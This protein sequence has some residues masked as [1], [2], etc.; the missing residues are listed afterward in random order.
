MTTWDAW[1]ALELAD[2]LTDIRLDGTD[3]WNAM[4]AAQDMLRAAVAEMER[5]NHEL[6]GFSNTE[7]EMMRNELRLARAVVEVVREWH[8]NPGPVPVGFWAVLN[9]IAAYDAHVAAKGETK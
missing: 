2:M 5:L 3:K 7:I 8:A 4:C 1:R 6:L 9:A